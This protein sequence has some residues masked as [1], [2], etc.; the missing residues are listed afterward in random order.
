VRG[1]GYGGFIGYNS[2][3]REAIFGI[4]LNYSRLGLRA[5]SLSTS[6]IS[7]SAST[8]IP[9]SF[10]RLDYTAD[11]TLT[12]LVTGRLRAGCAWNWFMPYGFIGAAVGRAD[13]VRSAT[14]SYSAPLP[15]VPPSPCTLP[16]TDTQTR[17][18]AIMAGYTAGFGVDIGL[19]ANVF[20]RAEYEFVQ[21]SKVEG[22]EAQV[23]S[24]RAA[25]AV[26]F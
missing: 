18:G 19:M 25:A 2:Q 11:M 7:T 23:N 24:V 3:W 21:L 6:Y 10:S 9:G 13:L 8:G 5:S 15:C 4:E 22:V 12:D 14:V 26:K 17:N 20:L 1:S 16:Y